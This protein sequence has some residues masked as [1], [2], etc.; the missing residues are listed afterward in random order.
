MKYIFYY[1]FVYIFNLGGFWK[2]GGHG[3]TGN[4][5]VGWHTY[6]QYTS[7]IYMVYPWIYHVYPIGPILGIYWHVNTWY[8]HH[9]GYTMY[10]HVTVYVGGLH[11]HGIYHVHTWY[12]LKYGFQMSDSELCMYTV[13]VTRTNVVSES[14]SFWFQVQLFK[15][16]L[17][18][19]LACRQWLAASLAEPRCHAN[20]G[21]GMPWP[22]QLEVQL[23]A[24]RRDR[25]G[26]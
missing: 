19:W 22:G 4:K 1:I 25:H 7:W 17:P 9:D 10:L 21:T 12:I 6:H 8:I 18:C 13:T 16:D 14:E 11:I 26:A 24:H 5:S 3:M 15:V 2:G 23:E 20:Y